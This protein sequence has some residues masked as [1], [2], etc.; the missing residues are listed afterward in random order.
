MN[1]KQKYLKL[2][3][4]TLNKDMPTFKHHFIEL[5]LQH[6][7]YKIRRRADELGCFFEPGVDFQAD[8][9]ETAALFDFKK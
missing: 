8:D 7:E 6:V 4:A 1:E 2:I 5:F 9:G 3:E